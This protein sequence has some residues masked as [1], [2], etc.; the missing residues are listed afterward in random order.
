MRPAFEA[1]FQFLSKVAPGA[2]AL[3]LVAFDGLQALARIAGVRYDPATFPLLVA[4]YR[5]IPGFYG[6]GISPIR[7]PLATSLD[8]GV[9]LL[10]RMEEHLGRPVIYGLR[11]PTAAY[12]L[13]WGVGDP[14][15]RLARVA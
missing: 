3:F 7:D 5:R 12:L 9:Q 10:L 14:A 8:S 13:E 11:P 6:F 1:A 15:Y 2:P 4:N